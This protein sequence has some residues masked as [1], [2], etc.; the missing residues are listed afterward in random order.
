M[1]YHATAGVDIDCI[2]INLKLCIPNLISQIN[3]QRAS[4]RPVAPPRQRRL[5]AVD[6][7][8]YEGRLHAMHGVGMVSQV[9]D[10]SQLHHGDADGADRLNVLFEVGEMDTAEVSRDRGWCTVCTAQYA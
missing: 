3:Y 9:I 6:L 4:F 5:K 8:R 7:K 2:H 10:M 1:H